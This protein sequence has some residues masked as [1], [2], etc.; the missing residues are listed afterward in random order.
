MYRYTVM[1]LSTTVVFIV[2]YILLDV[3]FGKPVDW[4]SVLFEGVIFGVIMTAIQ[5]YKERNN[6]KQK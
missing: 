3:I 1:A 2:V 4:T 6:S 5:Y